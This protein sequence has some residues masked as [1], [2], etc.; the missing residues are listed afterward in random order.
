MTLED[1]IETVVVLSD[2]HLKRALTPRTRI[3]S[4]GHDAESEIVIGTIPVVSTRDANQNFDLRGHMDYQAEKAREKE[5][6]M[7]RRSQRG[8]NVPE[9]NPDRLSKIDDDVET[10]QNKANTSRP[11]P[12][13]AYK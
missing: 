12:G 3:I 6:D 2:D 7:K 9:E 8:P 11:Y 13:Q 4:V 10:W 5:L 1:A